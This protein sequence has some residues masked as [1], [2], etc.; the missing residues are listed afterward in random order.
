ML[1]LA[2]TWCH[3]TPAEIPTSPCFKKC[4]TAIRVEQDLHSVAPG[5]YDWRQEVIGIRWIIRGVAAAV[6]HQGCPVPI[7]DLDKVTWAGGDIT[8]N[9]NSKVGELQPQYLPTLHFYGFG[10]VHVVRI[11][12]RVVC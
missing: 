4:F 1:L 10:L 6:V 11:V 5:C 3:C 9:P 8:T 7:C 2:L 12:I